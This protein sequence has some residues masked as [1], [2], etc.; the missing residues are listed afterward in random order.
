M[1]FTKS[2]K[3]FVVLMLLLFI[4]GSEATRG[5]QTRECTKEYPE[6][7]CTALICSAAC[8]KT[9]GNGMHIQRGRLRTMK[10]S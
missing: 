1:D 9:I 5:L 10:A 7:N 6:H 4:T 3:T 8:W 2:S